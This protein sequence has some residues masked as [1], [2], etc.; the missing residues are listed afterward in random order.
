MLNKYVKEMTY[1][2]ERRH[3]HLNGLL[4]NQRNPRNQVHLAILQ[5]PNTSGLRW[6]TWLQWLGHK[7]LCIRWSYIALRWLLTLLSRK[8]LRMYTEREKTFF[9]YISCSAHLTT[10]FTNTEFQ[11]FEI[12]IGCSYEVN[13][14]IFMEVQF[15]VRDI[16][17][18]ISQ[19]TTLFL[20]WEIGIWYG[21]D[22]Y[23]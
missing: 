23:K 9:Y 22:F 14:I 4:L 12:R 8:W 10:N 18:P 1:Q 21:L 13:K 16:K 11:K 6:D 2:L 20:I 15:L 19:S 7:R 5:A 3:P 17:P